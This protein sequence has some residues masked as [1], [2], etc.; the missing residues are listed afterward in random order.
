MHHRDEPH[1]PAGWAPQQVVDP[2]LDDHLVLAVDGAF[3]LLERLGVLQQGAEL[4]FSAIETRPCRRVAYGGLWH[5]RRREGVVEGEMSQPSEKFVGG[6]STICRRTHRTSI[7]SR[8][9]NAC[10]AFLRKCAERAEQALGRRIGQFV[11]R[12]QPEACANFFAH[13][14]YAI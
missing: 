1:H 9:P 7:R 2:I 12:L 6:K 14:G 8:R 4:D 13:A 11:R 5:P 10:K 3:G